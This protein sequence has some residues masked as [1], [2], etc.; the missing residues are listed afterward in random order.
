M[1]LRPSVLFVAVASR[2]HVER[3]RRTAAKAFSSLEALDVELLGTP[4]PI[5]EADALSGALSKT[6]DLLVVF[7][8]SGGTS[9]LL[10]TALKGREAI[11]WAHPNNNSLPSALSARE[12]LRALGAWRAEIAFS[13]PD[14]AP[15]AVRA[16]IAGLRALN[17]LRESEILA[18]CGP[19]KA[20]ELETVLEG[21]LGP[22][23]PEF[24]R[25]EPEELL[26]K[27]EEHTA[28]PSLSDAVAMLR[29]IDVEQATPELEE[30]LVRSAQLASFLA[31]ELLAGA[32]RPI[33]TFDCFDFLEESG[34]AP[35]VVLA[36]LMERGI[37]AVCEADPAAL[38][39]MALCQSLTGSIPWMANLARADPASGTLM[40]AHCTA[41]PS[42]SASWPYR[43]VLMSHFESGKP[44]ALDVWLKRGPVVLANLQPG[45]KRLVL[46]RGRI[47]DSGLGEEGLCRTQALVELDG[48]VRAFLEATS[49]HHI[50]C[51]TDITEEL[52]RIGR[53]LGLDVVRL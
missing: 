26:R 22:W 51:Y 2:L 20:A 8:S 45:V 32:R 12:K 53:R 6:A 18:V 25:L 7:V 46:A 13:P 23:R 11:V 15:R 37:P 30:G 17:E 29:G 3:A 52:A 41:C 44:V 1:S 9:R 47:V 43:G 34:L 4:E 28:P 38:V 36:L 14:K 24:K 21:L 19:E 40:L 31:S 39:L 49:N 48:D 35:C 50:V 10:R 27:A 5:L 42:L 33:I 16:E